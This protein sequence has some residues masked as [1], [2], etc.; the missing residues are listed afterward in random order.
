MTRDFLYLFRGNP[1]VVG[2]DDAGHGTPGPLRLDVPDER[3]TKWLALA[4]GHLAGHAGIGVYPIRGGSVA[5]GCVDFDEGEH[6][7]LSHALNL[8]E[9][10]HNMDLPTWL[11]RSRSKGYHLWLFSEWVSATWMRRLLLGACL[12][13]QAPAKEVNPKAERLNDDQIGNFVRLPYFGAEHWPIHH[14]VIVDLMGQPIAPELFMAMALEATVPANRIEHSGR[15]L[16]P[17]REHRH[18]HEVSTG[19]WQDRLNGLARTQLREGPRNRDRSAYLMA[20]GHACAESGLTETE[21]HKAVRVADLLHTNKYAPRNDADVRYE[22][23]A[24]E[25]IA[26]EERLSEPW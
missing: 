3:E 1:A 6:E 7:S 2:L 4:E 12:A 15:L 17:Q 5:W 14:Q 26:K 16:Q 10:L 19:P 13:V 25:A 22:S 23:I 20:F 8:R 9:L 18:L 21:I 11:E 24:Q